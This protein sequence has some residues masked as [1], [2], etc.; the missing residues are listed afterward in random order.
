M[1]LG[2]PVLTLLSCSALLV[3]SVCVNVYLAREAVRLES[4]EAQLPLHPTQVAPPGLAE[5]RATLAALATEVAT[6]SQAHSAPFTPR[7]TPTVPSTL[8]LPIPIPHPLTEYTIESLRARAYPGGKI[9]VRSVLT[10]TRGFTRY[11]IDYPSNDPSASSGQGPS[12]SSG[13]ALT[14]TGI[15]QVPPGEGPFPV[16]ILNHGYIPRERYWSGA[17]TWNAAEYLNRR[18]YLTVAPDFR[19]WGG[20]DVGH[21]FFSTGQVIDALNLISSLSSIPEADVERVGMWGHS[22]GGGV[23]TKAITIDPRVKAAVLYAPVSADDTEVLAR[24]GSGCKPGPSG[25]LAAGCAGADVLTGDLDQKLYLAYTAAVSD[26][27][28]LYQTSPINYLDWVTAP[29]QIHV[30]TF[31]TRTPPEWSAAIHRALQEAGKE[32]EYYTY[33]GQGHTLEGEHWQLFME[34]VANFFDRHLYG[35]KAGGEYWSKMPSHK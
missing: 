8:S 14:I 22:M 15:M 2:F 30:G 35:W 13:R 19:S 33:S 34:R 20:S 25:E 17:D 31:D 3:V 7:V 9:Q 28:F 23:T 18:G 5:P 27:Q 10:T 29:V 4:N 26:P 21:S 1:F 32:V 24:W 11:Y 6:L 12:E 16:V